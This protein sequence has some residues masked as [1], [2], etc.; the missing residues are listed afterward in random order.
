[1]ILLAAFE[2]AV[3]IP[4]ANCYLLLV[5][6]Q[7]ITTMATQCTLEEYLKHYPRVSPSK[8]HQPCE[9][10][11]LC[12]IACYID[13]WEHTAPFLGLKKADITAISANEEKTENKRFA[14]L[15]RWKEMSGQ[16]ATYWKLA[17]V[18]WKQRRA[19]LVD[20]MIKVLSGGS[21]NSS[22]ENIPSHRKSQPI[23]D[24]TTGRRKRSG[25]YSCSVFMLLALVATCMYAAVFPCP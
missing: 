13:N 11:H 9:D 6:C 20:E 2:F 3:A 24:E 18:F 25:I 5:L 7:G 14:M 4:L 19:D 15:M 12:E 10:V 21:P 22:E 1:M 16:T 23:H 17:T 8:L